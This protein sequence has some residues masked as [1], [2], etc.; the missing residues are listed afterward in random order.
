MKR[1]RI[2]LTE[3]DTK[4]LTIGEYSPHDPPPSRTVEIHATNR[5]LVKY[6]EKLFGDG[7]HY[8]LAYEVEN[9]NDS[10]AEFVVITDDAEV[11]PDRSPSPEPVPDPSPSPEVIPDP[12]PSASPDD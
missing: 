12:S 4:T 5:D 7:S 6:E 3:H 11:V 10:P 9:R 8:R 2:L 1:Y